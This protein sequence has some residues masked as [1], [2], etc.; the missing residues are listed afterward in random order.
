M[1]AI[2]RWLDRFCSKHPRFGVP[3]LM[4]YIA[5][6]NVVVYAGDYLTKG[7][8]SW[9]F[10]FYPELIFKGQ[11]WRL[12]TFAFVP[13]N[14]GMGSRFLDI[15]FFAL[16][17]FFYFQIGTALEQHWGVTRFSLFYFLGVA[18]N[19]LIGL[20]IFFLNPITHNLLGGYYYETAQM[21]Y[22]NLSMFFSFATL[23]PNMQ[24]LFWGIVPLR[25]KWLAYLDAG[26]FVYDIVI[27]LLG[28]NWAGALLPIIA[29]LNYLIFFWPDLV[30]LVRGRNPR[31]V[32][33]PE[34]QPINFKQ[35]QK[36]VKENRG[37]LHKCSV[38]GITDT[39]H[40]DMEFRYCSKCNG[41]HCY[42]MNHIND[43]VHVL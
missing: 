29:I 31:V 35:A 1:K 36:D 33:R 20:L 25:V 13:I 5:I 24:V 7:A 14:T 32:H 2:S 23:Y 8:L 17:T 9:I 15:L 34:P 10:S 16:I 4:K 30:E 19:A 43:H 28:Q 12:F 11:V 26:F 22:V 6:G 41:Y 42:C 38:C 40:P 37:Y 21:Y 39:D 3:N 27:S 18:L